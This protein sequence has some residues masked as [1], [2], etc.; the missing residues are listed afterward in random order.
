LANALRR[1]E[2]TRLAIGA[3]QEI[4]QQYADEC[5]AFIHLHGERLISRLA[6]PPQPRAE[7]MVLVPVEPSPGL[8][9]SMAIRSDH[10]LGCAGYYDQFGKE[11][12]H[13][14][15]MESTMRSMR[16][17]HEEVVGTGF[18]SPD[19]EASYAALSAAPSEGS[20]GLREP[21]TTATMRAA[22]RSMAPDMLDRLA[23]STP[24]PASQS[25]T[26]SDELPDTAKAGEQ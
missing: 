25:A 15:R 26:P 3:S 4:A 19:R 17:L 8:L 1:I 14:R 13:A 16:Q 18:Y 12:D 22:M 20:A 21:A 2:G 24:P 7:G 6:P 10:A 23:G 11:G 9:A 5:K